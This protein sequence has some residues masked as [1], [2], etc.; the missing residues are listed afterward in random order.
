MNHQYQQKPEVIY[1]FTPNNFFTYLLN[2]EPSNLM[3]SKTYN[4][5]FDD[6]TITF[7]D[8]NGKPIETDNKVNLTL[9]FDKSKGH[10]T[11]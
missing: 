6:I 3:F 4:T 11:L 1:T 8:Q 10:V 5:V 9:L 2:V 7:T